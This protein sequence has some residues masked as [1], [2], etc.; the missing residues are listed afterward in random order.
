M[1]GHVE[2][3]NGAAIWRTEDGNLIPIEDYIESLHARIHRHGGTLSITIRPY[4][5]EK[6][7]I[8]LVSIKGKWDAQEVFYDVVD[9]YV[10]HM[11]SR[12]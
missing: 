8:S 2:Y 6:Y 7:T 1:N 10:L 11:S 5:E 12:E 3:E 4:E 9:G